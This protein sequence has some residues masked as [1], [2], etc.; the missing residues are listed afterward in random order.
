MGVRESAKVG[1]L[2][3]GDSFWKLIGISCRTAEIIEVSNR[4]EF[5]RPFR[6]TSIKKAL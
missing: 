3:A 2:W 6:L 1:E 5:V 4:I